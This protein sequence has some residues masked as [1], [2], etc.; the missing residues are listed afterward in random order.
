[1]RVRIISENAAEQVLERYRQGER[2]FRGWWA[3]G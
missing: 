1:M 3:R 2:D